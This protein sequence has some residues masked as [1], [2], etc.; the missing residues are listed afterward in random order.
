MNTTVFWRLVWKEYRQ[1]QALLIAIALA[2]FIFQIA[3]LTVCALNGVG[4][5]PN[6]VFTV[7]LSVPILYALGC[8]ATLFAGEHEMGTFSFQQSLPVA[9][10]QVFY[11]KLCFAVVSAL[12]LFPLL[13][14]VAYAMTSWTLPEPNWHLQ[15]WGGGIVATVEL[16]IWAVLGSLLLRRVLPAAIASGVAA[17]VLSFGSFA[18]ISLFSNPVNRYA[19]EYFSTLPIQLC[20]TLV[21]FAVAIR[22]GTHWFDESLLRWRIVRPLR[23]PGDTTQRVMRVTSTRILMRLVSHG[24]RLSRATM[25][26]IAGGYFI[27]GGWMWLADFNNEL[28]VFALVLVASFLGGTTFAADQ[29]QASYLFFTEHGVPPRLVW[30]SRLM[31]SL[32]WLIALSI[33]PITVYL[34]SSSRL[35]H[36][37]SGLCTFVGIGFT[38]FACGQLCS[39]LISSNVV[40]AFTSL[41]CT[42]VLTLWGALMLN[43]SVPSSIALA[44]LPIVFFAASWLYSPKWLQQRSSWRAWITTVA[45]ILLPLLGVVAATA[46]YRVVEIPAIRSSLSANLA[47]QKD[48]PDARQTAEMYRQAEALLEPGLKARVEPRG[49]INRDE[50]WQKGIAL[51]LEASQRPDCRFRQW[52]D[53]EKYELDQMNSILTAV[54]AEAKARVEE[55]E[56]DG[57][58]QLYLALLRYAAHYYQQTH[59]AIYPEWGATIERRMF[60]QLVDWAAHDQQT[61]ENILQLIEDLQASFEMNRPDWEKCIAADHLDNELYLTFNRRFLQ[62]QFDLDASSITA[63]HVVSTLL[64]WEKFRMA[65]LLAVQTESE[66]Q[67]LR[68]MRERAHR[69]APTKQHTLP[70]DVRLTLVNGDERLIRSTDITGWTYSTPLLVARSLAHQYA[71]WERQ[72]QSSRNAV[73]V[74]LALVA[75]QKENGSHPAMLNELEGYAFEE[76][77]LDPYTQEP[78]VYFPKGA[79]Y[80]VWDEVQGEMGFDMMGAGG[81][82]MSMGGDGYGEMG[83]MPPSRIERTAPLLWSPGE[84]LVYTPESRSSRSLT[85]PT[86]D[87]FTDSWGHVVPGSEVFSRGESYPLP[88]IAVQPS[89]SSD[90]ADALPND[91]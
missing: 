65:R 13:W 24:F 41:I 10:K 40:A 71:T 86:L 46:T 18:A 26:W 8:G 59:E 67:G 89:D 2:G 49:V 80:E 16:L 14:L 12:I 1:Q 5:V 55:V 27:I 66:L 50:N 15:L 35:A 54:L 38:A 57:T 22:L 60:P 69:I 48:T 90:E 33:V 32:S 56:M 6:K 43:F 82:M 88:V 7:A 20:L 63:M 4:E 53:D 78:F 58:K 21:A 51:F 31:V 73:L 85:S 75:W 74:Q 3:T 39:I 42:V 29:R 36:E 77:P 76:L 19:N 83:A 79:E 25:L 72:Y 84:T 44:P 23:R 87:R 47:I 52:S 61:P 11:A 81:G 30:L 17:V 9:A 45:S 70:W 37:I 28:L 62:Q 64:P 68:A 91:E 34:I